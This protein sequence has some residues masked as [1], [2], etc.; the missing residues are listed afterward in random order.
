MQ[1]NT[2]I[3]DDFEVNNTYEVTLKVFQDDVELVMVSVQPLQSVR[4]KGRFH[5]RYFPTVR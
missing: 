2:V 1:K 3:Y 4:I 5:Y